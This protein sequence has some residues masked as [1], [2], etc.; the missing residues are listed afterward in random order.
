MIPYNH[1]TTL[2]IALPI[3]QPAS[4][5]LN[6]AYKPRIALNPDQIL[7]IESDGNYS[8]IYFTNGEKYYTSRTLKHWLGYIS[9][10]E[11]IRPTR[12]IIINKKFISTFHTK[13]KA[14]ELVN[15]KIFYISRRRVRSCA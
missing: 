6:K 13:T 14:I 8:T 1:S 5:A 15:G 7:Y 11:F 10:I 4:K 9:S 12:A 2:D 3:N